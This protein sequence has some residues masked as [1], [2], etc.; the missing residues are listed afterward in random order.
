[1]DYG[2]KRIVS[3]AYTAGSGDNIISVVVYLSSTLYGGE[4]TRY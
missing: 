4:T 2:A 1:M 3:D